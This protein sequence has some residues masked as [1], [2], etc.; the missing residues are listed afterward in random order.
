MLERVFKCHYCVQRDF[1]INCPMFICFPSEG[2]ALFIQCGVT[3]LP[4]SFVL[5]CYR[6]FSAFFF[7]LFNRISFILS[8]S[9]YVHLLIYF[10]REGGL[11][12]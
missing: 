3:T 9:I 1:C 11:G 5:H 12:G 10:H 2:Q 6:G 7:F 8:F 4:F